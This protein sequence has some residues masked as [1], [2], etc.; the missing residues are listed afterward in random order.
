MK[1]GLFVAGRSAAVAA[2]VMVV[3]LTIGVASAEA[4]IT[5]STCHDAG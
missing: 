1:L 2:L 5:T 3:V 4:A